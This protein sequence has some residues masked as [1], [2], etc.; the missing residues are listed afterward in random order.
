MADMSGALKFGGTTGANLSLQQAHT[1]VDT[2]LTIDDRLLYKIETST[3]AALA[4][5]RRHLMRITQRRL[6][7]RLIEDKIQYDKVIATGPMSH[8]RVH[9]STFA[10]NTFAC[11]ATI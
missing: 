6:Y 8:V 1:C 2:Y 5:A 11:A 4:A 7:K 10:P 3:D 9:T